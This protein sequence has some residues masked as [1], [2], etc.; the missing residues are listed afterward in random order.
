M[1]SNRPK[2]A[3]PRLPEL[4]ASNVVTE[5]P[6]AARLKGPGPA[7]Y[8][9]PT[10]IGMTTKTMKRAPAFSFGAKLK[11][12]RPDPRETPGP[13]AFFPQATR[14]GRNEGP[15]FSLQ[16]RHQKDRVD[17][18]ETIDVSTSPGPGKYNPPYVPSREAK[19][20]AY[21][22]GGRPRPEKP[23]AN[24][25]PAEYS[26]SRR[27]GPHQMGVT[28]K[29]P[30]PMKL[31]SISPGPA[32]YTPL[33]CSKLK[34]AAPAYSLGSRWQGG[35]GA[36]AESSN[37]GP[38]QYSPTMKPIKSSHPQFSFRTKHS[39]YELFIPDPLGGEFVL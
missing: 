19:A 27:I 33:P 1:A 9:L 39:E 13:N 29:P 31:Q 36:I 15:A 37:P 14:T 16:G 18:A 8:S 5:I 38:G 17:G 23:S 26:V 4:P 2:S 30:R 6:I 22:I 3:N 25:G 11:Y 24:P 20:P 32:A 34:P 12:E 7:A 21:S 10:T 35:D 28:I